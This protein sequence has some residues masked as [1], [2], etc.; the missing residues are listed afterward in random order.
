MASGLLLWSKS[1]SQSEGGS[2]REQNSLL[3]LPAPLITSSP[4]SLA[5]PLTASVALGTPAVKWRE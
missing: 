3:T 5:L 2:S 1:R 4:A